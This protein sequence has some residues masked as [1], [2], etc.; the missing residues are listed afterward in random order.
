MNRDRIAALKQLA[1]FTRKDAQLLANLFRMNIRDRY[2]GSRFGS[3]WA[4]FTP[5]LLMLVYTFVFGFVFKA[6]IPG[7]ETSLDYVIW[8]ISG[9]GIWFGMNEGI[10]NATHSVVSSSGLIKNMTFRTDLLPV[11]AAST[12]MVPIFVSSVLL[13]VLMLISGTLPTWHLVLVVLIVP[14]ALAFAAAVGMFT[15]VI[16]VFSRDFGHGLPTLLLVIMFFTPIF[17]P[18]SALPG[19]VQKLTHFNPFYQ[20]VDAYRRVLIEGVLPNGIGLLYVG[21]LTV[22]LYVLGVVFFTRMKSHC[23]GRL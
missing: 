11:A 19:P 15:S 13:V 7:S 4:V 10:L 14:L 5:L 23:V 1:R 9:L 6:K 8:L 18:P 12:G 2:L 16:N 20:I 17:Y 22:I 3:L 21:S